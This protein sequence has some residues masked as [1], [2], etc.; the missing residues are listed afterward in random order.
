[1]DTPTPTITELEQRLTDLESWI[2][3]LE[4]S[5]ADLSEMV[6]QQWDL[7]DRLNRTVEM[8][9]KRIGAMEPTIE[10]HKPPHY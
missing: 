3:H 7:I 1:M 4:S 10:A 9:Y 5:N 2:S 6:S 8:L